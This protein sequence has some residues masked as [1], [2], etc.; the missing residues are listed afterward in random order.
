MQSADHF[1]SL[2]EQE[3]AALAEMERYCAEHPESP[4]A[5]RRPRLFARGR[6]WVA[7]H[8]K[9][10]QHGVAAIGD[11]VRAALHAF[12]SQ[13]GDSDRRPGR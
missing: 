12:D 9:P 7:L 1:P 8:S 3:A 10:L 13:C 6:S 4:A 11:S 2:A 5:V